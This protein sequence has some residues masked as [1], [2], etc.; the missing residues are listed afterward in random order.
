[1]K[2]I[3]ALLLLVIMNTTFA[4]LNCTEPSGTYTTKDMVINQFALNNGSANW[5]DWCYEV[6]SQEESTACNT[7]LDQ[8]DAW[9]VCTDNKFETS[10]SEWADKEGFTSN[11]QEYQGFIERCVGTNYLN[12]L[13]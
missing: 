4:S 3:S 9:V 10:C 8:W 12:L 2:I 7:E 6:D 13:K 1:V 5:G 11:N